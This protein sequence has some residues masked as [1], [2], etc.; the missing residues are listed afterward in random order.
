M[1]KPIISMDAEATPSAAEKADASEVNVAI[2]STLESVMELTDDVDP[3]PEASLEQASMVIPSAADASIDA[4]AAQSESSDAT[5]NA[6]LPMDVSDYAGEVDAVDNPLQS[7]SPADDGKQPSSSLTPSPPPSPLAD[8]LPSGSPS[9]SPAQ[10]QSPA[11]TLTPVTPLEVKTPE[12]EEEES[13]TEVSAASDAKAVTVGSPTAPE[14]AQTE[15]QPSPVPS[16]D[17]P[18]VDSPSVVAESTAEESAVVDSVPAVATATAV[19][20][21]AISASEG[22]ID[23]TLPIATDEVAV[24][25]MEDDDDE[26]DYTDE[27]DDGVNPTPN[28]NVVTTLLSNPQFHFLLDNVMKNRQSQPSQE[29][30]AAEVDIKPHHVVQS[31]HCGK[32]Q[33]WRAA[34]IHKDEYDLYSLH[35]LENFAF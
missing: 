2:D 7:E 3:S 18:E 23:A 35:D 12:V 9:P 8:L 14:E 34:I 5:A 20:P 33:K 21:A 4:T 29:A 11:R 17:L 25:A 6:P 10:S 1:D 19:A 16:D 26:G 31:M 27:S 28:S 13:P 22:T 32:C 15:T 24:M 30:D